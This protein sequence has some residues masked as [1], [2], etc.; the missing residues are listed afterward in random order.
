M[1]VTAVRN[2][3]WLSM[4]KLSDQNGVTYVYKKQNKTKKP[5]K[6]SQEKL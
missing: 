1:T 4:L 2:L 3:S 5:D 6:L